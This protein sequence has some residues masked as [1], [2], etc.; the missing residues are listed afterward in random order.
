MPQKS[1]FLLSLIT[2]LM[3]AVLPTLGQQSQAP[4]ASSSQDSTQ[5]PATAQGQPG[6]SKKATDNATTSPSSASLRAALGKRRGTAKK[7]PL[8]D[9]VP[10]IFDEGEDNELRALADNENDLVDETQATAIVAYVNSRVPSLKT[11]MTADS[12]AGT[13]IDQLPQTVDSIL[14]GQGV[15]KESAQQVATA[16]QTAISPTFDRPDDVSCS[17]SLLQWKETS[18]SFGRRVANDYIALQV[19][20]RNLNTQSEFLIHDIQIAVDTGLNPVQFGRFQSARD[21]LIVRNVAQRAQSED[22][23]N[24]VINSLI[25]AGAIAG[26]A[27]GAI[28]QSMVT[29]TARDLATAVAIFQ[30]PFIT[31]LVNIFPDHTIENINHINDQTFSASSTSKTIVPIQGSVPL[32][33]FLVEKPIEQLP[34]SRCGTATKKNSAHSGT[35]SDKT[36]PGDSHFP[37]CDSIADAAS[38]ASVSPDDIPYYMKPLPYRYWNPAALMILEHRIFVVIGGV[39]IQELTTSPAVTK[40]ACPPGND[41]TVDLATADKTSGLISCTLTG[42]HLDKA[43]SAKLEQATTSKTGTLKA[44]TDGSSATMS[45]KAT[46]YAGAS[47]KF[48][49]FLTDNAKNDVDTKQSVD[50]VTPA[51]TSVAYNPTKLPASGD[52][53][54]HLTGTGLD[55][56]SSITLNCCTSE[57]IKGTLS[58]QTTTSVDVDFKDTDLAPLIAKLKAPPT[59]QS[60]HL[61]FTAINNKTPQTIAATGA[62]ISLAA[63]APS[64]VAITYTPKN[65]SAG[66]TLTAHLTG[67]DLDSIQN[68]TINCCGISL[69]GVIN[70]ARTSSSIDVVFTASDVASLI[71]K[72][73]ATT[74][75]TGAELAFTTADN[76]TPQ[77]ISGASSTIRAATATFPQVTSAVFS[78]AKLVAGTAINVKL[79]GTNLELLKTI[80]L[81]CCST[82]ILGA[83]SG[84]SSTSLDVLFTAADITKLLA[85]RKSVDKTAKLYFTTT[86]ANSPQQPI[87][88]PTATIELP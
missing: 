16:L 17:F 85:G 41:A 36:N 1:P 60:A 43:V 35:A 48:E 25:A 7:R 73:K 9:Y 22:A 71:A 27:S 4:P 34:F 78:S 70:P 20:V 79:S 15:T 54:A 57:S 88:T 82:S 10:C 53:K 23:R 50:F 61:E 59:G 13:Q 29:Q 66:G 56:I 40:V 2:I 87:K 3:L 52:L 24:I 69:P 83:L 5:N 84:Q 55:L 45:I 64:N 49:L 46:D 80:S 76:K 39:H 44:A 26:G 42:S 21:K 72:L 8:G 77:T 31:G 12:V 68:V 32:V 58:N 6:T 30:G 47:G 33:T 37:Y 18:D 28:T 86:S 62:D 75:A 38:K 67:T 14:E 19:T 65:L 63:P 74:T 81:N 51:I 11:S